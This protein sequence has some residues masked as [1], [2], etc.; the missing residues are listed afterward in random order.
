MEIKTKKPRKGFTLVEIMVV[1]VILGILGGVAF[2][3]MGSLSDT[4]SSKVK[5]ANAQSI[6]H[7]LSTIYAIGGSIGDGKTIDTT[8]PESLINSLTKNPP[9]EIDEITFSLD[10]KPNPRAYELV[11][12]ERPYKTLRAIK[13][14]Q[15][16]P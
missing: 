3:S 5:Q 6:N 10:P 8:S 2:S 9:V 13:G 11:S 16:K 15:E 12:G 4:A 1:V 14:S 7:M